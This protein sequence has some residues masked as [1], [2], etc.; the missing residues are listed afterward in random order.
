MDIVRLFDGVYSLDGKL[1]TL[2][3][4]GGVKVYGEEHRS[5][6]GKEYRL[7]NPYRSK[8]GAAIMN[9]MRN[10]NIREG[11]SVLYLGAATGT[12]SSHVSDIVGKR[13]IVYCVELSERNMRDLI[14]VCEN[15]ANML[16]ILG[17]ARD[18][19]AYSD[20]VDMCDII[21]QDVS[22]PEQAKILR[23]NARFLKRGGYAYFAIKSQSIDIKRSPEHT[24]K[25][26]LEQL[27]E[28][29]EIVEEVRI[30]PYHKL[31]LFVVLRKRG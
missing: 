5:Y 18:T 6:Q 29:F 16:P 21:Y 4:V 11:D 2:S 10:E 9:G 3:L 12:T 22:S 26:A 24:F 31:H 20:M 14:K 28:V 15:R 19:D 13:G 8:L 1:A 23:D 7:W 30:E 17:D 27:D 25:R